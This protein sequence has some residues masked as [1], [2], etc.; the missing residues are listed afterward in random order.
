MSITYGS[1]VN[2]TRPLTQDDFA[3]LPKHQ[4]SGFSWTTFIRIFLVIAEIGL[5]ILAPGAGTA[6]GAAAQVG[7]GLAFASANLGVSAANGDISGIGTGIDFASALIPLGGTLKLARGIGKVTES[8]T[9]EELAD[10]VGRSSIEEAKKALPSA[11]RV[12]AAQRVQRAADKRDMYDARLA[13]AAATGSGSKK[14]AKF[15]DG[16]IRRLLTN[17]L[18]KEEKAMLSMLQDQGMTRDAAAMEVLDKLS[19]YRRFGGEKELLSVNELSERMG[20]AST[21]FLK[22]K[23]SLE[24]HLLIHE[25]SI[26]QMEQYMKELKEVFEEVKTWSIGKRLFKSD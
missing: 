24:K 25:T 14:A 7:I 15:A 2:F 5:S 10:I 19:D 22:A 12:K 13:V 9:A 21:A 17:S 4:Q 20:K 8:K 3:N 23:E 6:V 18:R 26:Q 1:T 16:F 11:K